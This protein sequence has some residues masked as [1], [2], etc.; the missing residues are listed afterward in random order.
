MFYMQQNL[1]ACDILVAY[2]VI[3]SLAGRSHW[4]WPAKQFTVHCQKMLYLTVNRLNCRL[5]LNVK[6]QSVSN[7]NISA[8]LHGIPAPKEFLNWENQFSRMPNNLLISENILKFCEWK[9][10]TTF[11]THQLLVIHTEADI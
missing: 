5:R 11:K 4:G 10:K 7:L 9:A 3:F 1:G 8:D 2:S 6:F